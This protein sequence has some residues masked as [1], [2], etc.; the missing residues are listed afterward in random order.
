MFATNET[1]TCCQPKPSLA[2][3]RILRGSP[4][5]AKQKSPQN[6]KEA[7]V[8][9]RSGC[10][11]RCALRNFQSLIKGRSV[12]A[13]GHR[14]VFI[15]FVRALRLVLW[16]PKF[17]TPRTVFLVDCLS[18]LATNALGVFPVVGAVFWA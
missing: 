15:T 16:F 8:G 1:E 18:T 5:S 9:G 12:A 6:P 10:L 11:A 3:H 14:G 7:S 13:A 2:M 4:G 17:I